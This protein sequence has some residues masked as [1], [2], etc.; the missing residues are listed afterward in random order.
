MASYDD[1]EVT[2][3]ER[4]AAD[5]QKQIGEFNTLAANRQLQHQKANY[6]DAN[7]QNRI[8]ANVQKAQTSRKSEDDKFNATRD[9]Q[10]S[11]LGLFSSMGQAMN[12]SSLGNILR[13]L[14]NRNDRDNVSYWSQ[15]QSGLDQIDNAYQESVNQNV[16][17]QND[18]AA[19]AEK[20]MSDIKSDTATNLSNINPNLY[21][22]PDL[23]STATYNQNRKE[24]NRAKL[25][26]YL[27]PEDSV[28]SARAISPRNRLYTNDYFSTLMNKFNGR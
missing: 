14:Q 15:L 24:I 10:N 11:A 27:M 25:S 17:A 26:G 12:G 4:L 9:L 16:I 20:A 18:A 1:A 13:M 2:E 22:A 21:E 28:Q 23:A 3:R 8:L 19:N 7:L 5:R 6:D